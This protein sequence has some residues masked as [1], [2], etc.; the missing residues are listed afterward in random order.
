M[1]TVIVRPQSL[2]TKKRSKK[3][4][5]IVSLLQ[6]HQKILVGFLMLLLCS[7]IIARTLYVN[8]FSREHTIISVS[9]SQN[10]R[11]EYNDIYLYELIQN[12]LL[13]KN[14]YLTIINQESLLAT[15]RERFP[16]VQ[17]IKL[18]KPQPGR[19]LVELAFEQPAIVLH[20]RGAKFALAAN[21]TWRPIFSGSTH[22]SDKPVL[23]IPSYVGPLDNLSGFFF[24]HSSNQ[25]INA[26]RDIIESNIQFTRL[27]YLIGSDRLMLER[28]NG[29]QL[30]ISLSKNIPDQITLFR[31]FINEH[32]RY[33][34]TSIDNFIQFDIG[35]LD[36]TLILTPRL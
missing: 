28:P 3:R 25:L 16:F 13:Q 8:F 27:V 9:F 33:M 17:G 26:Y 4:K 10:N 24:A 18:S 2:R 22:G 23:S 36:Q 20:H 31:H 7:V 14:Y 30:F 34:N 5:I 32:S 11:E 35:S 1:V 12:T 21:N 15:I 6:K 19:V 29:T